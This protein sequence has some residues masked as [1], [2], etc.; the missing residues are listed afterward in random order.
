MIKAS[1]IKIVSLKSL[2]LNPKNRNAHPEEQIDRLVK[3]IQYQGFRNPLIVSNRS[4]LVVAGHG[5]YEAAKRLELKTV[6]VMFQDFESEEQEYAAQVSD[7]AIGYWSNLDLSAINTDIVDLGPDFD[8]DLLGIKGFTIDVADKPQCDEDEIPGSVEPRTKLG[9]IY[10]LGLHR[11]MCGNSTDI[12][13]V[14]TLCTLKPDMLLTDPPYGVKAVKGGSVGGGGDKAFGSIGGGGVLKAGKY[15][16]IIG[17]D[18]TDTAK[19]AYNLAVSLD[20]PFIIL[21]GGNYY[22]EFCPPTSAWLVWDKLGETQSNNFA[23]C[24]LAWTNQKSPARIYKQM[25]RGMIKQGESGKRVHPTQKPVDLSVWCIDTI[26]KDSRVILD[27]FGGSGSTMIACEKSMRT[28]FTMELDP[29]YCD[30]IVKRWENYTGKKAELLNG[31][32]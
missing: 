28:C 26:N 8:I 31:E 25:W 27:L 24:E 16:E 30:V 22:S 5:R 18:T 10:Q 15:K 9:D 6:P 20:I 1:E 13:Q 17:D 4:G 21:W 7:N 32:S 11:L 12:G 3:I 29:H 2:K 14:E 23:D 19:D